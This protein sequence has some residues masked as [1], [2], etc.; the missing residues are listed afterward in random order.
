MSGELNNKPLG[1]LI[2]QYV[3]AVNDLWA[4]KAEERQPRK[5]VRTGAAVED[6]KHN[7][8]EFKRQ[9]RAGYETF[10]GDVGPEIDEKLQEIHV[11]GAAIRELTADSFVVDPIEAVDQ[12][13]TEL[14][15]ILD[16]LIARVGE[17]TSVGAVTV[18]IIEAIGIGARS[19]AIREQIDREL[20]NL[21]A[22]FLMV[23]ESPDDPEG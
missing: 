6:L 16:R 13:L 19:K 8:E 23:S 3:G 5:L 14:R 22:Y 1:D 20:D 15:E 21:V 10:V 4:I 7:W 9:L 2:A 18:M 17:A 11:V 12:L